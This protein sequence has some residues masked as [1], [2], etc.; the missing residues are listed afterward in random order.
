[1]SNKKCMTIVVQY[2]SD[3][4]MPTIKANQPVLGGRVVGLAWDDV[5]TEQL[6]TEERIQALESVIEKHGLEDE[7]A[8]LSDE[9]EE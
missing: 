7:V 6:H 1:M 2:D 5:I 8:E 3:T 4:D 9:K